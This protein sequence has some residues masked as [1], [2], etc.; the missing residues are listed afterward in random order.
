M[1]ENATTLA[2]FVKSYEIR[3]GYQ[4]GVQ[5]PPAVGGVADAIDIHCHADAAH[6]DALSVARLASKNGMRGL[7]YKSIAG[8][9]RVESVKKVREELQRWCDEEKIEPT[10]CWSGCNVANRSAPPSVAKVREQ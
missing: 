8:K 1:S 4:G 7:L 5:Y 10:L 6:Q 9:Q 3:R 2:R